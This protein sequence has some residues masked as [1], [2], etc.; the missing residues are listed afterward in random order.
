MKWKLAHVNSYAYKRWRRRDYT[1]KIERIHPQIRNNLH[2]FIFC[3][4]FN[5]WKKKQQP[6]INNHAKICKSCVERR[7]GTSSGENRDMFESDWPAISATVDRSRVW[8]DIN[9]CNCGLGEAIVVI[10]KGRERGTVKW[11]T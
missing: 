5:L 7:E 2:W 6:S 8:L 11:E 10:W 3:H 1:D 9:W 4:E